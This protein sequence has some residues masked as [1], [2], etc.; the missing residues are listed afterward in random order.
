MKFYPHIVD[1]EKIFQKG[2]YLWILKVDRIPPHL[3]LSYNGKYYNL[4]VYGRFI[5]QSIESLLKTIAQKKIQTLIISLKDFE[6]LDLNLSQSYQQFDKVEAPF[7]TCLSPIRSLFQVYGFPSSVA[8]IHDLLPLLV[9]K[10]V[11][12]SS[13]GINLE[14]NNEDNSFELPYYTIK[15]VYQCIDE[16]NSEKNVTGK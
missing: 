10:D 6:N 15:D 4:S 3:I 13:F 1:S 14:L 11:V 5:G 16:L 7:I 8:T 9:K 2:F 12:T